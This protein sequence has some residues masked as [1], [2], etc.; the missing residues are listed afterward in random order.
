[1][2]NQQDKQAFF[3]QYLYQKVVVGSSKKPIDCYPVFA[4]DPTYLLLKNLKDISDEDAENIA[5]I[6]GIK[7]SKSISRFDITYY[8][9]SDFT[10]NHTMETSG[11]ETLQVLDYLRSKGYLLPFREYT[12]DQIIEM[13][14]AKYG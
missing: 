2:S 1:M 7:I 13:G 12:I 11:K 9:L 14:W 3:A 6:I 8:Y 5:N 10:D 4:N